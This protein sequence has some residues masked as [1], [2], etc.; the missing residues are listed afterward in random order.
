MSSKFPARVQ[1]VTCGEPGVS[2]D[3]VSCLKSPTGDT[4]TKLGYL[5]SPPLSPSVSLAK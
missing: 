4:W 2:S 3:Q 5:E 1:E